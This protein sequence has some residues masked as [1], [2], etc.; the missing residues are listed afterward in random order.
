MNDRTP[1]TRDSTTDQILDLLLDALVHPIT[2][3]THDSNSRGW[4]RS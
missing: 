3:I 4:P 2:I 1:E